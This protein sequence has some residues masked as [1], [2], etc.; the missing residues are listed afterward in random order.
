M[1]AVLTDISSARI[2]LGGRTKKFKGR[3]PG[4]AEETL[5]ALQAGQPLYVLG[6]FGGCARDIAKDM[7]ISEFDA[8]TDHWQGREE[9]KGF[10]TKNLANGLTDDENLALARTV[11]VDQAIAL[12]L[13]G[14]LR[15]TVD[16]T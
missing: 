14:M 6:G 1:R 4:I 8:E 10:G 7:G 15:L 11:H 5:F 9:F 16:K 2:V 13:R 12:I 3:M